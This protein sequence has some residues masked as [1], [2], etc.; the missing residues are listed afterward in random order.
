[1]IKYYLNAIEKLYK[2]PEGSNTPDKHN[3]GCGTTQEWNQNIPSR[4]RV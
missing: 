4:K 2:R 3:I 1:M